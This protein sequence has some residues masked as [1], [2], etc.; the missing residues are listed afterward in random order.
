MDGPPF[1]Y[2]KYAH[3]SA[4]THKM[5]FLN[6]IIS[7]SMYLFIH[8]MFKLLSDVLPLSLG[9]PGLLIDPPLCRTFKSAQ[10]IE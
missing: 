9:G 8:I 1:L 5:D 3:P 2:L 6:K 10:K 4:Y 7:L